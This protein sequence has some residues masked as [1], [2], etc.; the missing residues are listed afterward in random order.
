MLKAEARTGRSI[1]KAELG[2]AQSLDGCGVTNA[3]AGLAGRQH[4]LLIAGVVRLLAEAPSHRACA[5]SPSLRQSSARLCP[6]QPQSLSASW[7]WLHHL[8]QVER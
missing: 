6:E 4:D 2:N 7:R 8:Q 1:L 5:V 3:A